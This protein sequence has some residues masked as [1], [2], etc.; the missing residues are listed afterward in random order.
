MPRAGPEG[1]ARRASPDD[2]CEGAGG[3]RAGPDEAELAPEATTAPSKPLPTMPRAG[4]ELVVRGQFIPKE[5]QLKLD[6]A[7]RPLLDVAE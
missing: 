5:M 7:L 3:R 6:G 2:D 4:P 1:D